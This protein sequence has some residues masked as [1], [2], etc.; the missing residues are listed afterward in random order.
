M[1]GDI[2]RKSESPDYRYGR[3]RDGLM[4]WTIAG[5]LLFLWLL[6]YVGA[7][8]AGAWMHVSLAAAAILVIVAMVWRSRAT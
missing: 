6:G 4:L 3:R 8:A 1:N 5:F 7:F 2:E